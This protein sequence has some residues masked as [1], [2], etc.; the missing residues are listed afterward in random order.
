M[1]HAKTGRE[2]LC[3]FLDAKGNTVMR[4]L[5]VAHVV[6]NNHLL[7]AAARFFKKKIGY[8][9]EHDAD[10]PFV[11]PDFEVRPAIKG[12]CGGTTVLNGCFIHTMDCL[13]W[14]TQ[15]MP[16]AILAHLEGDIGP[17]LRAS[18]FEREHEITLEQWAV[19]QPAEH[20][21]NAGAA[22]VE[23]FSDSEEGTDSAVSSSKGEEDVS[24]EGPSRLHRSG[25][26]DSKPHCLEGLQQQLRSA[27]VSRSQGNEMC[28]PD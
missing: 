23:P 27:E 19:Q 26:S 24:C 6:D 14:L 7:G 8:I 13:F 28:F 1:E 22:A 12:I 2:R 15:L 4:L 16:Q 9:P 20:G 5:A 10:L 21:D 18:G 17:E 3:L 25:E 11:R